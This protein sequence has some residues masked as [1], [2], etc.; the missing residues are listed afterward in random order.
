MMSVYLYC[1]IDLCVYDLLTIADSAV[2][3]LVTLLSDFANEQF[4]SYRVFVLTVCLVS[5]TKTWQ[6]RLNECSIQMFRVKV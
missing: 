5:L 1:Y 6:C 4:F 2:S 3:I